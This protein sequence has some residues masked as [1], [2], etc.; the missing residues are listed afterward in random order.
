MAKTKFL[1]FNI[2]DLRTNAM[3][4]SFNVLWNDH[5]IILLAPNFC[6]Y[7]TEDGQVEQHAINPNSSPSIHKLDKNNCKDNYRLP[8]NL[9]RLCKQTA[10]CINIKRLRLNKLN[11]FSNDHEYILHPEYDSNSGVDSQKLHLINNVKKAKQALYDYQQ[12]T[13]APVGSMAR[14]YVPPKY[15]AIIGLSTLGDSKPVPILA[16]RKTTNQKGLTLFNVS[17]VDKLAT[18]TEDPNLQ[19][20]H[21]QIGNLLNLERQQGALNKRNFHIVPMKVIKSGKLQRE[22]DNHNRNLIK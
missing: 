20:T 6:A 16:W 19:L 3:L 8:P 17:K 15:A 4:Q 18:F 12:K 2:T 1:T 5:T 7:L 13:N 22:L 21:L 9:E 14:R 11:G 10:K